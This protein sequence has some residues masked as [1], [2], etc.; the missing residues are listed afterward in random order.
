MGRHYD[1]VIFDM[2]GTLTATRSSWG[3]IH[4]MMEVDNEESLNAFIRGE[5]DE[6]EFMRRDIALWT[7]KDPDITVRDIAVMFRDMP[8]TAG[9]QETVACLHY[10]NIKCVICSGGIDMA[11]KMI[12]EEYG[13]DDWIADSLETYPD[14]RLTGEG[15]MKVD[16][17]DKGIAAKALMKKFNASP[18]R[19][20]S[21]GNSYTDL[22][23]FE[24]TGVSIA[25]NPID[26]A[27][28]KAATHVIR[29]KNLS[30][31]LDII[32]ETDSGF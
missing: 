9:I 10:N 17:K 25:F 5:I 14:G 31:V 13:F 11:A 24:A 32:M 28:E 21:V 20:V 27:T 19:T 29:S 4:E 3:Y 8:L 1:L 7:T 16:L 30:D 6:P 22:K 18:E 12:A 2:D 26:E 15:I 23:M